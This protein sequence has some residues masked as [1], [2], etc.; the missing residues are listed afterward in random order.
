M[1]REKSR[2]FASWCFT[3]ALEMAAGTMNWLGEPL[4]TIL[5]FGGII[6]LIAGYWPELRGKFA[7]GQIFAVAF[8]KQAGISILVLSAIY[9]AGVI[10]F[11]EYR[12]FSISPPATFEPE[13]WALRNRVF[14]AESP[15]EIVAYY[16]KY[17]NWQANEML[18]NYIGRWYAVTGKVS[19]VSAIP[20]LVGEG[21]N[22]KMVDA[23]Y[24][25]LE[26]RPN[27]PAL[28]S[29]QFE[30][31]WVSR[32]ENFKR[33]ERISAYCK[34]NSIRSFGVSLDNCQIVER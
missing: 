6:S 33:G 22:A 24:I 23:P 21:K 16:T 29:L 3:V 11:A 14:V 32:A 9:W 1:D 12:Y 17:T 31:K 27:S 15:Q 20:S 19:D 4:V 25:T 7:A 8:L 26:Y 34:I 5:F 30:D 28:V 2:H 18:K 10:S 13:T